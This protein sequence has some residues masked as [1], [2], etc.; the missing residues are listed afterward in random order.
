[1]KNILFLLAGSTLLAA[2]SGTSLIDPNFNVNPSNIGT[3]SLSVVHHDSEGLAIAPNPTG[4]KEV[5]TD[6]GF[7]VHLQ[8]AKINW[9]ELHLISSGEDPEC[10][11]G[12]D[13]VI[14]LN[15][16]EDFLGEDLVEALLAAAS[17]PKVAYREFELVLAPSPGAALKFHE[18]EDHGGSPGEPGLD[19]TYQ[20]SGTWEKDAASGIFLLTGTE[21][22]S[23]HGHFEHPLHFH[24]GETE[25]ALLFGSTYDA[26]LDG[27]DFTLDDE[28]TQRAKV[29][30]NLEGNVHQDLGDGHGAG[31]SDDGGH[32]H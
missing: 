16:P 23:V 1:M 30:E 11:G 4:E 18:G 9:H 5:E 25:K 19:M 3:L 12:N 24:E 31:G 20:L 6:L 17:V 26:L 2:C 13:Q 15:H 29:L 10:E 22:L 32:P 8:E 27:I 14:A 28:A 21:S 7:H